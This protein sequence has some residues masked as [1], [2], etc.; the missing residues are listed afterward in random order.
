[1]A[2]KTVHESLDNEETGDVQDAVE[3]G[4][5]NPPAADPPSQEDVSGNPAVTPVD[6]FVADAEKGLAQAEA[7]LAANPDNVQVQQEVE[8][9]RAHLEKMR[10]R[11]VP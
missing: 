8:T 10:K 1:M 6:G 9:R 7:D 3:Q 4:S 2:K 5:D 11:L